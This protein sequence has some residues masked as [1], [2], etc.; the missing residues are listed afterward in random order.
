GSLSKMAEAR[1]IACG[2]NRAPGRLETAASKGM[3]QTTASA[4]LNDFVY[5]RRM[6]DSTPAWVGSVAALVRLRAVIA[7]S[8]VFAGMSV[9]RDDGLVSIAFSFALGIKSIGALHATDTH[10]IGFIPFLAPEL[11]RHQM[12]HVAL[13]CADAFLVS[14]EGIGDAKSFRVAGAL[15]TEI[16]GLFRCKFAHPDRHV[17]IAIVFANDPL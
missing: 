3:P 8:M 7:W 5:I 6:N 12:I 15:D 11:L 13:P 1:R 9:V 16:A 17:A 14:P 2:P 4:P 10:A